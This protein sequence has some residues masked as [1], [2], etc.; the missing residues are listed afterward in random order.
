MSLR[1]SHVRGKLQENCHGEE[2]IDTEAWKSLVTA[3]LELFC[4]FF[5]YS[6]LSTY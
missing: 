5:P 2:A 4:F 6:R 1:E 3:S